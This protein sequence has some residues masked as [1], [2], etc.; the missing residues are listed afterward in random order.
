MYQHG[1]LSGNVP[2]DPA[3]IAVLVLSDGMIALAY[4]V[5][6]LAL[7]YFV[8][9]HDLVTLDPLVRRVL[10]SLVLFIALCGL[11]HVMDLVTLVVPIYW[12]AAY[13]K[14]ATSIASVITA[15][16][17]CPLLPLLK[18]NTNWLADERRRN[19]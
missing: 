19:R 4:I 17:L 6:P 7:L 18:F 2:W 11:S 13:I 9:R 14:A 3:L 12:L 10:F 8:R 1:V 5:I 15:L 16:T